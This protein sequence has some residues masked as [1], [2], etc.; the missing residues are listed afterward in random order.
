[1]AAGSYWVGV[2]EVI[3]AAITNAAISHVTATVNLSIGNTI[4]IKLR[5]TQGGT[6]GT[7]TNG[8]FVWLTIHKIS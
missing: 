7:I 8:G 2:Y 4:R 1:M 5:H 6:I 3:R